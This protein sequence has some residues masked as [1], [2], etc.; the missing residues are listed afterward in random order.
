VNN[1]ESIFLQHYESFRMLG[2]EFI[3]VL[4]KLQGLV[5]GKEKE[6]F[7]EKVMSPMLDNLNNGIGFNIIN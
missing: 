3:L 2:I 6:L 4:Q 5:V 7:R 1:G